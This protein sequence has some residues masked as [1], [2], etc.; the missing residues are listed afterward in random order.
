MKNPYIL[1]R[2]VVP[3]RYSLELTPN[4]EDLAFIGR[5]D[6]EIEI[7]KNTKKFVINSKDLVIIN[8][9][10]IQNKAN[11]I[12]KINYNKKYE[13]VSFLSKNMIK[14]GKALLKLEFKGKISEG[15]HG[16]YKST[17]FTSKNQK[18]IMLTTQFEP[19]DARKCFPCFDEPDLKAKFNLTLIIPR[20]LDTVSNMPIKSQNIINNLK[21]I[22]FQE[23]P[24]MSTY[25]L[26][27]V[28]A[29]LEYLKGKTKN[30]VL[31]RIITT[32]GKKDK[33][34][35]ALEIAIKALEYYENYFRISYPLPKLDLIAI[36]D[37]DSGA[38]ENWGLI[39]YREAA[40]LFDE[41]ESS[42]GTKQTVAYII[43]HEIAHQW[44]GNLVTMKWWD[45]LWLNEGFASW[46]E[47]KVTDYLFPEFDM[48][49]QYL[50]D[51]RIPALYLDS[52]NNSHP[53]E[54]KV[55]DP[56][57]INEIFDIISY[58][59]GSCVIRVLE[60]YLGEKNFRSGLKYYLDKFKYKNATTNDL[61]TSL[62]KVSK[63]PVRKIMQSWTKQT[64][65]PIISAKIEKNK[66]KL[67]Q[68]RFFYLQ[69]KSSQLWHIPIEIYINNKKRYYLMKTKKAEIKVSG[70]AMINKSQVGFYRVKYDQELFKNLVNSKLDFIER[71]GLLNDTYALARGCYLPLNKYLELVY[72]YKNE[73]NHAVWDDL[74]TSLARIDILF[75]DKYKD[76]LNKFK[77]KLF[78][79]IY[80][81][82]GWDEK[83]NDKHTDIIL[84]SMVLGILGFSGYK[85]VSNEAI[86]KFNEFL[87]GKKIN[88]NIRAAVYNITSYNK[89][90]EVFDKL[91]ELYIKEK[92]QEEKIRLLCSLGAFKQKEL[93]KEA[94]EF[95]LSK[96]VRAQDTMYLV[97]IIGGNEYAQDLAWKFLKKNWKEFYKRYHD[98][99]TMSALIKSSTLKFKTLD[100]LKE[101]KKFFKKHD[102]PTARLAIR[103]VL[104][105]IKI[106]YKMVKHNKE[107][108]RKW[109]VN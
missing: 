94:L 13:T 14:K 23:T 22:T 34:K 102:A 101:V 10:I 17:Y 21:K 59:K 63:K 25:L 5:E 32:R 30:N 97:S 55:I 80:K 98:S 67:E 78:N 108:M 106:N 72:N 89:G 51:E 91:K 38:M 73:D 96:H 24:T 48:W 20:Y 70:N 56:G 83:K 46:M 47:Y 11:K 27:F 69:K 41:K 85:E 43:C 45:D 6:I 84:R 50:T 93:L 71:L 4:F 19:S 3:I 2:G 92:S 26:A 86:K 40:L 53:I 104:E 12:I 87:K 33:A 68:E 65:Y 54:A 74:I 76:K 61:W 100:R 8:A 66:L 107:I 82:L 99:H 28:I 103:Q 42:V 37:F 95:S 75:S 88:P 105:I 60:E 44:F 1:P 52:L 15:L 62:E 81:K 79:K 35:L 9:Q 29:E 77:I 57:K 49:S 7:V 39:T 90:K 58:N 109:K 64:G 31:V 36:P 16:L 18:K